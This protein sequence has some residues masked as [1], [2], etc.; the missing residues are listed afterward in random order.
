[1]T[2]T[3]VWGAKPSAISFDLITH[4]NTS[5]IID[6]QTECALYIL[7]LFLLGSHS[8]LLR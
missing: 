2:A 4:D 7:A 3:E 1:M 6:Q 5:P 8:L